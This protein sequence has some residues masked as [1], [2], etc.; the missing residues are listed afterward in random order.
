MLKE[1]YK[2]WAKVTKYNSYRYAFLEGAVPNFKQLNLYKNNFKNTKIISVNRPNKQKTNMSIE[3][4]V[5]KEFG[6][7]KRIQA[8]SWTEYSKLLSES[9]ILL[10]SSKADTIKAP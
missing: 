8:E 5:E 10:I 7:I 3:N 9:E 6:K 1:V 2:A 4:K